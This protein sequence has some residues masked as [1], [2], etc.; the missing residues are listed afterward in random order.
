MKPQPQRL[1]RGRVHLLNAMSTTAKH[2]RDIALLPGV[3]T[4]V[5]PA[6]LV[7]SAPMHV[8]WS[9]PGLAAL[10]PVALGIVLVGAGLAMWASTVLLFARYAEGT[11]APWEPTQK[12]VIRGPYRYVRNPMI[13]AVIAILLGEAVLYGSAVLLAWAVAFFAANAVYIPRVEERAMEA[14]FGADYRAY[15]DNVPRW[16]PRRTPWNFS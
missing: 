2:L 13:T 11:L 1:E 16:V 8:G 3:V 7:R 6:L 5:V 15:K 4:L 14:R 12:L 9:L 10:V